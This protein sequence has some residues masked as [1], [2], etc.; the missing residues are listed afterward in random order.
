V[1]GGV[2]GKKK[3]IYDVWGDTVNIAS[4]ME[5]TGSPGA[6]HV[7]HAT[8]LRIQHAYVFEDRGEI[9]VKGK[10]LMRTWLIKERRADVRVD[11]ESLVA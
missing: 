2:I 1:V 8:Y 3:F 7:S 5:S 10:G 6:V 9:E 11:R 4:R